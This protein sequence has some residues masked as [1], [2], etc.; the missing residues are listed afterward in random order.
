MLFHTFYHNT[1]EIEK[2]TLQ[3]SFTPLKKLKLLVFGC[4]LL[5]IGC[6][7]SAVGCW[8]SVVSYQFSVIQ[9]LVPS[10]QHPVSSSQF[11]VP[12]FKFPISNFSSR[13][14]LC[15]CPFAPLCLINSSIQYP[16]P[17]FRYPLC[18]KYSV[19]C[20]FR[21]INL[22]LHHRFPFFAKAG[23]KQGVEFFHVVFLLINQ[24]FIGS[25][26]QAAILGDE[27][28]VGKMSVTFRRGVFY[29]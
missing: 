20:T 26:K 5:A 27:Q 8:L 10:F 6:Q 25:F 16:V 21:K 4:W 9:L 12:N 7:L 2:H 19:L 28:T 3:S 23:V 13:G 15:L 24:T 1:V 29:L 17:N 11:P 14:T 18:T 22:A